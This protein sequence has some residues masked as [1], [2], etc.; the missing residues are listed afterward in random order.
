M[1]RVFCWKHM[2]RGSRNSI[3]KLILQEKKERRRWP[4]RKQHHWLQN[5][6]IF[7][8]AEKG[9]LVVLYI[10][11]QWAFHRQ[12]VALHMTRSYFITRTSNI[13]IN[14]DY[15]LQ[16]NNDTYPKRG[17][18]DLFIR[19]CNSWFDV[20]FKKSVTQNE[21]G[22]KSWHLRVTKYKRRVSFWSVTNYEICW[23]GNLDA[24]LWLAH[25][26]DVY[27]NNT[28]SFSCTLHKIV[29]ISL[30]LLYLL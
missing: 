7:R 10:R 11:E 25:T 3:T 20:E 23:F 19:K 30:T 8:Q 16:I 13:C 24:I 4:G 12:G 15:H 27:P 29:V 14:K 6:S 9:V 5:P 26:S 18:Q 2:L 22:R 28:D 21:K 17:P 1:R